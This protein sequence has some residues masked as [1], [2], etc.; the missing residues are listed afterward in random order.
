MPEQMMKVF[1]NR[2]L[3]EFFARVRPVS[4]IAKPRC[5]MKTSPAAS[6]IQ[7]LLAVK[8]PGLMPSSARAMPGTVIARAR[9]VRASFRFINFSRFD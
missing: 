5:M 9:V 8:R 3:T 7:T 2:M 1:L 4:S 6:I